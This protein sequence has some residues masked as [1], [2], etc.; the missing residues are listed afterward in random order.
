MVIFSLVGGGEWSC[1]S[2]SGV[3]VLHRGEVGGGF[4]D[5]EGIPLVAS[6]CGCRTGGMLHS[7]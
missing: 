6:R 3:A 4:K 5:C 1:G 7:D 2:V